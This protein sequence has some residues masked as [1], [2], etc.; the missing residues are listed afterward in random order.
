MK[1]K[2]KQLV[3]ITGTYATGAARNREEILSEKILPSKKVISK[4]K[5]SEKTSV[6]HSVYGM[7][8]IL[9]ICNST[10]LVEFAESHRRIQI[11]LGELRCI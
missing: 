10:A 6:S 4:S 5:I 1:Y 11:S 2:S 3:Y 9:S 8:Q 7:G